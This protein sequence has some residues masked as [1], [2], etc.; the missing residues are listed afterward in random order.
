MSSI[1]KDNE[2]N[3]LVQISA[4][5]EKAFAVFYNRYHV[6][7]AARIMRILKNKEQTEDILQDVF[8]KIWM[9]R[10]SILEI[11]NMEAFLSVSARN[12]CLNLLKANIR[13]QALEKDYFQ[14]QYVAYE[15]PVFD[16]R[17]ENDC[18][19]KLTEAIAKLPQQQQR[20]YV[21]S[22]IDR[23][24]YI[25]IADELKISKETVKKYLQLANQSI[26]NQLTKQKDSVISFFF[27]FFFF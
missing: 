4:G 14:E 12:S 10:E 25:E 13:K 9:K 23:K 6:K 22:R 27:L 7:I 17:S 18:Y 15:N 26:K 2:L 24:K 8:Y 1:R 5:D 19:H 20:V 3:I 21:L 16:N 11:D